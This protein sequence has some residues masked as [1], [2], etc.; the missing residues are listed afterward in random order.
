MNRPWAR[1]VLGAVLSA[2]GLSAQTTQGLISGRVT[3]QDGASIAN[4]EIRYE[5]LETATSGAGR[6]SASGAPAQSVMR[7]PAPSSTGIR[8]AKS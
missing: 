5:N 2:A 4:A 7:P 1:V 6:S 3:S 8:A